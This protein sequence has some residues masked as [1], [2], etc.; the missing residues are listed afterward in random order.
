[1]QASE[2]ACH[3]STDTDKDMEFL[4]QRQIIMLFAAQPVLGM[5]ETCASFLCPQ[6]SGGYTECQIKPASSVC[7]T[8]RDFS[9]QGD[10]ELKECF[11]SAFCPERDTSQFS[12]F[13]G[14]TNILRKK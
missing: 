9:T 7:C 14:C 11:N 3:D 6:Y 12:R 4:G 13:L 1:M 8:L 2:S 10:L 5:A